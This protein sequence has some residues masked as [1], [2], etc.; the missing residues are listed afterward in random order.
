MNTETAEWT[1][2]S[3]PVNIAELSSD[4]IRKLVRFADVAPAY[5]FSKRIIWVFDTGPSCCVTYP[6]EVMIGYLN[7]FEDLKTIPEPEVKFFVEN[8]DLATKTEEIQERNHKADLATKTEEIQERNHKADREPSDWEFEMVRD[9][10]QNFERELI[11]L[12]ERIMRTPK[13]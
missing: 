10:C 11:V 12:G 13:Q 8:A 6:P 2:T 3:E 9:E 5:H 7:A 4:T 1:F